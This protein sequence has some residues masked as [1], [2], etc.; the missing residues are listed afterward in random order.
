[1]LLAIGLQESRFRYR[2]QRGGPAKSYWQFEPAGIGG[3]LQHHASRP[4]ALAVLDA[5]DYPEYRDAIYE[6]IE[7]ND[8]LSCCFARLLLFTDPAPLPQIGQAAKSW[9]YY[10]RTWRPGRPRPD[11]WEECYSQAVQQVTER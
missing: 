4:H 10:T 5:L 8:V 3:A 9:S 7:D 1:M 2:R 6:A 11:T